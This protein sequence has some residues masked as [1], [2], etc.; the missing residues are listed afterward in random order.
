MALLPK[1]ITDRLK[2]A[3]AEAYALRT[4]DGVNG[5]RT[6]KYQEQIDE[7]D[8]ATAEARE[9]LPHLYRKDTA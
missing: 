7:I 6:R 5:P 2:K 3:G 9:S 4:A 1:H 8:A